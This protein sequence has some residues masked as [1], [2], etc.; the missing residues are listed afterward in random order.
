MLANSCKC[1][2][3]EIAW[4]IDASL[5]KEKFEKLYGK[6]FEHVR[7]LDRVREMLSFHRDEPTVYNYDC[8]ALCDQQGIPYIYPKGN[9]INTGLPKGM[10]SDPKVDYVLIAGCDQ[11]LDESGLKI[12]KIKII[13]YHYSPLPAYRG[14]NVVVWQ[15]FNREPYIGYTFHEVDLGIDTGSIIYQGKVDYDP[16]EKIN[17]VTKRVISISSENICKVYDCLSKNEKV[18]LSEKLESSFYSSKKYLELIT[19]D[20]TKSIDEMYIILKRFGFIRLKNGIEITNILKVSKEL[21]NKYNIDREGITIPLR[22]GYIKGAFPQI[23]FSYYNARR[24]IL[25]ELN[26]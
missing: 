22:D 9:S 14:K 3:V 24:K 18:L 23:C 15:W 5:P 20:G 1:S 2:G 10:Y 11:I 21:S 19:A 8:R 17:D 6:R 4:F 26:Q 13:N 12:A 16:D 25:K 7:L